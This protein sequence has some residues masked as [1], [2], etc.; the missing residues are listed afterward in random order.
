MSYLR[1][2]RDHGLWKKI[3]DTSGSQSP[4][5]TSTFGKKKKRNITELMKVIDAGVGGRFGRYLKT[6]FS[7]PLFMNFHG[8]GNEF[9]RIMPLM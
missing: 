6:A 3:L 7:G 8:L 1:H 5:Q 2:H 9:H 4:G